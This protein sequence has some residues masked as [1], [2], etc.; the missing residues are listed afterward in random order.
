VKNQ[1]R[2]VGMKV[3][4]GSQQHR[5]NL[6]IGGETQRSKNFEPNGKTQRLKGI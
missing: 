4:A 1:K 3:A 5:P 6:F 2:E